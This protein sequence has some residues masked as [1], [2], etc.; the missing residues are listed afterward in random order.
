MRAPGMDIWINSGVGESAHSGFLP[1]M[2]FTSSPKSPNYPGDYKNASWV[3]RL[4]YCV[5]VLLL[6]SGDA[7]I[8]LFFTAITTIVLPSP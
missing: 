1:N 8:T 6:N 4:P 5:L 3:L 2:A 7:G